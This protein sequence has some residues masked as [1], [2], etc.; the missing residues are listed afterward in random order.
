[1]FG[2]SFDQAFKDHV[3]SATDETLVANL[4]KFDKTHT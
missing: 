4:A 3:I 2:G 1:M